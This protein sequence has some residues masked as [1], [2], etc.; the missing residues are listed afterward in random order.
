MFCQG[1]FLLSLNSKKIHEALG[2]GRFRVK[3]LRLMFFFL[4]SIG[5]SFASFLPWLMAALPHAKGDMLTGFSGGKLFFRITK[6][7]NSGYP[8][9]SILF[10]LFTLG[11]ISLVR[12][13]KL[14]QLG[15]LLT[16]FILPIPI[17]LFLDS[18][19]N[20]F[21]AIRQ[22]LFLTP[23]FF[24]VIAY[25]IHHLDDVLLKKRGDNKLKRAAC[26]LI[27][28]L[29]LGT[30]YLRSKSLPY[31]WKQVAAFLKSQIKSE[32]LVVAPNIEPVI[33]YYF[34]EIA[35]YHADLNGMLD[36]KRNANTVGKGKIYLVESKFITQSQ[37]EAG[38][39]L[40]K[41]HRF[42]NKHEFIGFIVYVISD[43]E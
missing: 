27:M 4:L 39:Q 42:I 21:F 30:V 31:E 3:P 17:I 28:V 33:G 15:L 26:T 20:Y 24:M 37:N 29:S 10:F 12:N 1:C 8:L 22:I 19:R 2:I 36:L 35:H 11:I 9:S 16:W 41:N 40:V 38:K 7:I 32:D 6:E 23:A 18:Y 43:T 14:W 34:P 5:I 25:G 13:N